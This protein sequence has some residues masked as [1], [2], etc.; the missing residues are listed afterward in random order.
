MIADKIHEYLSDTNQTLDGHLSHDIERL[1]GFAFRRQFMT[2]PGSPER[3]KELSLSAAGKC[4]RQLAYARHGYEVN[5]KEIDGRGRIIFFQGD[6]VEL[7]VM[8]LARL[9]GCPVVGTGLNQITVSLD[10]EGNT[11]LGHPDGFYIGSDMTRL[12]ECK[13]MNSFAFERFE[14]GNIDDSYNAQINAYLEATNLDECIMVAMN[15]DNGVLKELIVYRDPMV[16]NNI[17]QNIK[18]VLTSTKEKLPPPPSEYN[19]D[20]KGFYPWN[21]LYCQFWGHCRTGA[22]RVLVGKSYKLKAV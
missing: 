19:P 7:T 14:A 9:A 1:A 8:S 22:Q 13:S 17:K 15:K 3:T 21:C 12:V 6:L 18:T 2:P 4:P 20:S 5:G 11:I 10:I 16:I